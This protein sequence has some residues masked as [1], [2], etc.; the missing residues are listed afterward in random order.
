MEGQSLLKLIIQHTIDP[1]GN[2]STKK[3]CNLELELL[4]EILFGWLEVIYYYFQQILNYQVFNDFK[5]SREF[6]AGAAV[7]NLTSI[8][9]DVGSIPGPTQ[10]V[11]DP[12]LP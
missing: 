5:K 1:E 7:M 8:H 9:E 10:W 6:C 11:K 4:I 2:L 12:V 3:M